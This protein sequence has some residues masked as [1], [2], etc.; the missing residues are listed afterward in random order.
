MTIAD[1]QSSYWQLVGLATAG[2]L[3]ASEITLGSYSYNK[4]TGV[5]VW[6]PVKEWAK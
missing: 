2:V 5:D 3:D 1:A 4:F 6:T